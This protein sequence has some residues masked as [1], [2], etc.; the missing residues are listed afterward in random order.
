MASFRHPNFSLVTNFNIVIP[1]LL[2][3]SRE[4]FA[5]S[6]LLGDDGEKV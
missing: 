1:L 5:V 3:R 6:Q 4:N 2:K